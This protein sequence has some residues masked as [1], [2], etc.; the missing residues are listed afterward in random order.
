MRSRFL[1]VD[2]FI[3][4]STPSSASFFNLPIPHLRPP[5]DHLSTTQ[6]FLWFGSP[7]IIDVPLEIDDLRIEAALSKLLADV[8]PRKIGVR[9]GSYGPALSSNE[10]APENGNGEPLQGETEFLHEDEAATESYRNYELAVL[11]DPLSKCESGECVVDK[12]VE[13][14]EIV[15]FE[16]PELDMH[17][18]DPHVSEKEYM[19]IFSE[20]SPIGNDLDV[21][22]QG[23]EIPYNHETE[24]SLYCFRDIGLENLVEPKADLVEDDCSVQGPSQFHFPLLEV[25]EICFGTLACMS[26]EDELAALLEK[27]EDQL[28]PQ[29]EDFSVT[30]GHTWTLLERALLESPSYDCPSNKCSEADFASVEIFLEIDFISI[31]DTICPEVNLGSYQRMEDENHIMSFNPVVLEELQILDV[32]PASSFEVFNSSKFQEQELCDKMSKG[33]LSCKS[34]DEMIVSHE[35]ALVDDMFKPLPIPILSDCKAMKSLYELNEKAIIGLKPQPLSA[36]DEIYLDWLLLEEEKRSSAMCSSFRSMIVAIDIQSIDFDWRTA[37]ISEVVL[38]FLLSD[39]DSDGLIAEKCGK[40]AEILISGGSILSGHAP[41][42]SN[43]FEVGQGNPTNQPMLSEENLKRASSVLNSMSS[44]NDLDFFLNPSKARTKKKNPHP[45]MSATD[46]V[47]SDNSMPACDTVDW[48]LPQRDFIL[49]QVHLSDDLIAVTENLKSSYLGILESNLELKE[50]HR[51]FQ[52]ADEYSLLSVSKLVFMGCIKNL[53]T[54]NPTLPSGGELVMASATLCAIKQITWYLCFYGIHTAWSYLDKLCEGFDCFATKLRVVQCF[55]VDTDKKADVVRISSH[56]SL[57]AVKEILLS[58]ISE[59]GLKALLVADKVFWSALKMLLTSLGISSCEMNE[60]TQYPIPDKYNHGDFSI[61]N[62]RLPQ[63][64]ACLLASPE[65]ISADFPF[66][67]FEMILEYG[68][69]CGSSRITTLLPKMSGMPCLHFL[70]VEVDKSSAAGAL[71]EGVSMAQHTGMGMV[72]QAQCVKYIEEYIDLS[73]L[74]AL[75]NFVPLGDEVGNSEREEF[76][77]VPSVSCEPFSAEARDIQSGITSFPELVIIMNTQCSEKEMIVSRRSTYQKILA[78]EKKGA[79]VIERDSNLPAD[80]IISPAACLVWY[81]SNNMLKKASGSLEASSMLPC[82]VENIATNVLSFLSFSFSCCIL[83]FEGETSFLATM[84]ESS[85]GLYAVAASLGIDLQLFCSDSAELTDEIILSCIDVG[86]RFIKGLFPKLPES[87]TSAESFLSKFPSINPLT[88][89]AIVSNGGILADFLEWSNE[90]RINAVQKYHVPNESISL[91]SALCRCGER[92]DSQ[93]VMTDSSSSVSSAPNSRNCRG[94]LGS[95]NKRCKYMRNPHNSDV[96]VDNSLQFEPAKQSIDSGLKF[97]E[98]SKYNSWEFPDPK[99]CESSLQDLHGA[100]KGLDPR[101]TGYPSR[102]AISHDFDLPKDAPV[103]NVDSVHP[104][105]RSNEATISG[106]DWLSSRNSEVMTEEVR[107]EGIDL[108]DPAVF[109]PV[110]FSFLVQDMDY[111]PIKEEDYPFCRGKG[112][113]FPTVAEIE[114]SSYCPGPVKHQSYSSRGEIHEFH[115]QEQNNERLHL[116]YQ[117]T[118][119]DADFERTSS[120]SLPSMTLQ[121][122]RSNFRG[123]PLRNALHSSHLLRSSPWTVEFLNRIREKSKMRQQSLPPETSPCPSIRRNTPNRAKRRSPSILEFFKYQGGST[124]RKIPEQKRQ[125]TSSQS[126][127]SFKNEK[128]MSVAQSCTPAD[129]RA[130]RTLSY[131]MNE[132]G[133]Q[134]RLVWRERNTHNRV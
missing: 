81:A 33:E 60:S 16:I 131:A 67:K 113:S 55:L 98:L 32:G 61:E 71:C 134:T 54:K 58:S 18:E 13:F 89:H 97:P 94:N 73:K 40:T 130:R 111:D 28:L 120:R 39:Y 122:G 41:A 101:V 72:G 59:N 99:G 84:M 102:V 34:F 74:E 106:L 127:C 20:F 95:E 117:R 45:A 80:I 86:T 93:S 78:L 125:K 36:S 29:N 129:K 118:H 123:T 112:R 7:Q 19:S 124:D 108:V 37:S 105:L 21:L 49:H 46:K 50:V 116:N 62:M 48:H 27:I 90:S 119:S 8:V 24:E 56:P 10:A 5:S 133:S 82:H 75:L 6:R 91:F 35:L 128:A 100:Q 104:D 87:E 83:I 115:N 79:Q 85:D 14:V 23:V 4:S 31:G 51:S 57:S 114:S 68:G 107:G 126:L 22:N 132:I 69:S 92:E 47:Q 77:A 96:P 43:D 44:F 38:D 11:E 88:A 2:Y 1:N 53:V 110:D 64:K 121:G 109:N 63:V 9:D 52:E 76:C 42:A 15:Q 65:N 26:M 30:Y 3:S 12:G 25:D 17:L 66:D 70:K 103:W